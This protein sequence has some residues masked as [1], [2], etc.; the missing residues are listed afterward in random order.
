MPVS[1]EEIGRRLRAAPEAASLTQ[2]QVA[3]QIGLSRSAVAQI[4]LGN[5]SVSSV[6]IDRL[7]FLYCRDIRDFFSEQFAGEDS[8]L[9]LFRT[10]QD[11]AARPETGD[12][13]RQ[14]V[15]VG[16]ELTNLERL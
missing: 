16:L 13:L 11:I 4:E 15:G 8:L 9:A 12:A 1:Q 2:E 7:A 6:E 10:N 14:C 3:D 5:R